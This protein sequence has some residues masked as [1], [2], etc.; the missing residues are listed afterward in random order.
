MEKNN[1]KKI[2]ESNAKLDELLLSQGLA[3]IKNLG[4]IYKGIGR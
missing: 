2:D 3:K 4:I 1:D